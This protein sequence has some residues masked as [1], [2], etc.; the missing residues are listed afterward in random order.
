MTKMYALST[1]S[2]RPLILYKSRDSVVGVAT[3]VRLGVRGIVLRFPEKQQIYHISS[4]SRTAL[5]GPLSLL[6]DEHRVLYPP[7]GKATGAFSVSLTS[8]ETPG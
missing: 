6:F 5:W 4:A 2:K 3:R 7:G 8:V 1:K